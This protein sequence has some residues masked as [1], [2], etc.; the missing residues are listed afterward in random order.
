[1]ESLIQLIMDNLF[2]VIIIIAG[3][4]GFV[5]NSSAEQEQEKRQTN[6]PRPRPNPSGGGNQPQQQRRNHESQSN[7]PVPTSIE[8]QQ[9]E[10]LGRL[11][12]QLRTETKDAMEKLPHDGIIGNT[13]REP[14][15]ENSGNQENLKR[16][17]KRNLGKTGLV[18]GII[19]S[20][21]LGSPRAKKPYEINHAKRRK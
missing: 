2:I 9:S 7:Q 8:E 14:N 13:L 18:N 15:K 21:V 19:M 4:I 11:A 5:R 10:Q 6:R 3:I 17:I 16:Q 12:N 20:E 1:M